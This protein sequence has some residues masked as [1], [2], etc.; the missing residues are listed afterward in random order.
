MKEKINNFFSSEIVQAIAPFF[1]IFVLSIGFSIFYINLEFEMEWFFAAEYISYIFLFLF[2][3]TIFKVR[4]IKFKS[5]SYFVWFGFS[6]FFFPIFIIYTIFEKFDPIV[7]P[8]FESVLRCFFNLHP[9][10]CTPSYFYPIEDFYPNVRMLIFFAVFLIIIILLFTLLKIN[11]S[12]IFILIFT[13]YS[14][15]G[16]VMIKYYSYSIAFFPMNI[17]VDFV[18][19]KSMTYALRNSEIFSEFYSLLAIIFMI[20]Y[21]L[22]KKR[23]KLVLFI[24]FLIFQF[25]LI[26]FHQIKY[27]LIYYIQQGDFKSFFKYFFPI[28]KLFTRF[29]I[30]NS[31]L[32]Y[33]LLFL[34]LLYIWKKYRD[35]KEKSI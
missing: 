10:S 7:R 32:L 21:I 19:K 33:L 26:H 6:L 25:I 20:F 16:Y 18:H 29:F 28:V 24:F 27:L 14:I 35:S 11:S 4:R 8:P 13:Y 12:K 5:H 2:L 30:I 31:N 15:Y 22:L 17:G 23:K 34:G 9:F 3:I 1:I